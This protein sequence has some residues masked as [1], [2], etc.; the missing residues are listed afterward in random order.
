M[1]GGMLGST[2][3]QKPLVI[4]DPGHGGKDPGAN[5]GIYEKTVNLHLALALE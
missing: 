4:I 2:I 1:L 5:H 3:A